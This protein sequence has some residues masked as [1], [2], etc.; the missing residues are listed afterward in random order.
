MASV[1]EQVEEYYKAQLD[2]Y[3]IRRWGKTDKVNDAIENA[4]KEAESKQGGSGANIPD[5]KSLLEDD[6]RRAIPVLFEAKG[7]KG[8]L[9]KLSKTGDIIG[10]TYWDNDGKPGKDGKPSHLKGDPNYSTISQYAVNGAVHYGRAILEHSEY[11]EVIVIGLNGTALDKDGTVKDPEHKAYYMSRKNN[12]LPK[13]IKELDKD[14]ILLSKKNLPTLYNILDKLCLTPEEIEKLTRKAEENLEEKIK[15]IHQRLY[16]DPEFKQA[17]GTNEKL[18]LFCGLIMAGMKAPGV[19]PLTPE[20]LYGNDALDDNDGVTVTNRIKTFLRKNGCNN[21][22][23]D[24]ILMLIGSVFRRE[25]MWKPVNGESAIKK[26]F[27]QVVKDIIP[28]FEGNLH[29]DFS[30]KILNSLNDWVSIENDYLNDVVLTPRY[31]TNFMARLARTNKDSL[32]WDSAMGSGGFLVSAMDIMIKDAQ[33][34]IQDKDELEAKIE[35]IKTNQICGV[36]ILGNIYVLAFLNMILMGNSAASIV[37]GDSHEVDMTKFFVATVFLLNPPYSAPGKGLIFVEEALSKM[38]DGY[39]CILIQE[40]AG[41]GQGGDYAKNI[42][43]KNTLL[44]S[45]H[46]PADLFGG[47]ASVQAAIYLF[48]VNRPH[49]VDDEVVFIDFS[50]DGY[51][52]QNRKKSTQEVN[53]CDTDNATGRYDEVVARLTGKKPKTSYCTEENSLLI[54]DTI[55][56]NGDDWTFSQHQVLDTTPTEEDFKRTVAGYL[57]WQVSRLM[58]EN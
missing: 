8:K 49:E 47:K 2:T 43:K 17:L 20:G 26:I 16:D 37:N 42:L 58:E 45:I 27:R 40:N 44:A 39:A 50:N 46:M 28:C 23:I 12:Y 51:S 52:R 55:T 38:I 54:K 36:E 15:A 34:K 29:L 25:A 6:Y 57:S 11:D 41:S 18:Y 5:I 3:G 32:V 53:L 24:I 21:S 56:L 4:L 19:A 13:H 48:K 7:T 22:N 10:I 33:D 1:E 30:G 9:E 31:V 35:N 14:L